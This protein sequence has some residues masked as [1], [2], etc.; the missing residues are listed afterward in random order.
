ML[1]R[2]IPLDLIINT[3]IAKI[4]MSRY[5]ENDFEMTKVDKLT[6]DVISSRV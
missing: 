1:M 2:L 4:F 6:G 3:E 5:I